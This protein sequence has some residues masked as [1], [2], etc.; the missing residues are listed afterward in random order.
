MEEVNQVVLSDSKW[1]EF[2][3]NQIVSNSIKYSRETDGRILFR[4]KVFKSGVLLEIEDNGMGIHKKDISKV[5][6]KSFTG[7]NGRNVSSSTGMGLYL[8]KKLCNK[9]GHDIT[10]ESQKD[11]YTKVS[12]CFQNDNYYN[13]I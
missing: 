8:A 1:I 13:V 4:T 5:F 9:L 3:I 2:I 7:E 11:S 6:D 12:I 10:I